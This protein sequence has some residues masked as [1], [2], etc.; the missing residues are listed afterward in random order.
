V[1]L[2]N[3]SDEVSPTSTVNYRTTLDNAGAAPIDVQVVLTV[4]EF[5]AITEAAGAEISALTASWPVTVEPGKSVSLDAAVKVGKI[6]EDILWMNAA[7][8]VSAPDSTTVIIG[9][10]DVDPVV[11]TENA[12]A[13]DA[14]E[15]KAALSGKAATTGSG[16][17]WSGGALTP[18]AILMIVGSVGAIALFAAALVL[19]RRRSAGAAAKESAEVSPEYMGRNEP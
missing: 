6:P 3:D 7:I 1:S 4:P 11:G 12:R 15:V 16:W 17:A 13:Q 10:A 5:A 8:V 18:L 2:S 9:S 19:Q 14:E